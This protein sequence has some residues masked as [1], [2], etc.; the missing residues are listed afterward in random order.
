LLGEEFGPNSEV[1]LAAFASNDQECGEKE[2]SKEKNNAET[3][4]TLRLRRE[5]GKAHSPERKMKKF[6]TEFTE[7]R[8]W[9]S[10]RGERYEDAGI[11]ELDDFQTAL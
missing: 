7:I 11:K 10:K 3:Q 9:S 2:T 8:A 1:G 4:R 6:N 5:E